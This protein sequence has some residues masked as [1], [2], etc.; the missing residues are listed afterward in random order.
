[1]SSKENNN[2]PTFRISLLGPRF[3]I[4][5]VSGFQKI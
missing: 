5:S 1:M 4:S 2:P 3:R